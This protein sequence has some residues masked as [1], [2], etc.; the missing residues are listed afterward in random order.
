M[1]SAA[2][3]LCLAGQ[4]RERFQAFGGHPGT[5]GTELCGAISCLHG[6]GSLT[7]L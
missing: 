3:G 7:I 4:P 1:P 2:S 5:G 6:R